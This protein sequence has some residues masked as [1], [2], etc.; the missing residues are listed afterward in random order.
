ML[1][2][3]VFPLAESKFLKPN[4]N[5]RYEFPEIYVVPITN[6]TVYAKTNMIFCNDQAVCHDLY[7]FKHDFT[8]E[9]LHGRMVF[10]FNKKHIRNME[11][12]YDD[13]N[14]VEAACFTDSCSANYSHW[15][16]EVLPRIALFCS[17]EQFADIPIIIDDD[18]HD[19]ILQSLALVVGSH[20]KVIVLP[21]STSINVLKLYVTSAVG[22][23]PFHKRQEKNAKNR[24]DGIFSGQALKLLRDIIFS[25]L[26]SKTIVSDL[27]KKIFI[28]RNSHMRGVQNISELNTI[29]LERGYQPV[30]PE[31]FSFLEQVEIFRG[32]EV[33]VSPTGASLANGIFC[34]STGHVAI[35]MAKHENMIFRYWAE[36]YK[37]NN[38][39]ISYILGDLVNDND[40]GIH[41]EYIINK[42]DLIEFLDSVENK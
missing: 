2:P 30:E 8:S 35:M 27:P 20:R 4:P 19:N 14:I 13:N 39:K 42:D 31:R 36:I 32:A 28:V 29:M 6:A 11:Y 33:I 26:D 1:M 25:Q 37:F 23:V 15:L 5:G 38:V 9:E 34:E 12:Y 21:I 10:S 24:H 17:S 22:Y 41:G 40:F 16:T 7:D 18:L 3:N